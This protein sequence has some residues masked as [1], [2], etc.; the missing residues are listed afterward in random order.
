MQIPIRRGRW[1]KRFSNN[2][3]EKTGRTAR[4]DSTG[5]QAALGKGKSHPI[6]VT[7]GVKDVQGDGGGVLRKDKKN[8][9]KWLFRNQ[10]E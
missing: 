2:Q 1:D 4:G 6:R 3:E 8:Q 9:G 7:S 10:F 5:K